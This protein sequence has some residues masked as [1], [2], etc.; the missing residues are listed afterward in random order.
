MMK[1]GKII[2]QASPQSIKTK[3]AV[4]FKIIVNPNQLTLSNQES[5]ESDDKVIQL[6]SNDMD[7]KA[8]IDAMFKNLEI[9]DF[10]CVSEYTSDQLTYIVPF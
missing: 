10:K 3:Y 8:T 9:E 7:I 4:G 1:Q 6:F 5:I 2:E